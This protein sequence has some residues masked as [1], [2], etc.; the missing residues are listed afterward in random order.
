M[1][2]VWNVNIP[3]IR[4]GPEKDG[5]YVILDSL[6]GASCMFGYGVDV[7][8]IFDDEFVNKYNVPAY[9]FDHTVDEPTNLDPKITF[10]KE[11]ISDKNEYPLFT[12]ETHVK[13]H[14]PDGEQFMLKMD[15]E[16]AEWDVFK[17]ADLSRVTQLIA[18]IHDLDKA[19]IEVLELI[20]EK[21][22]LVHIHGNNHPKQPYVKIDRVRKM[23]VVLECTWVRK[24]L[25]D[26]ATL[27]DESYPTNL[28]FKND[29]ESQELE[30]NFWKKV[31][32]P[33]TFIAPDREQKEFLEKIKTPDDQIVDDIREAKYS[34]IFILR[35]GDH[36]PYDIIMALDNINQE[37]SFVFPIVKNGIISHDV[38]FINGPGPSLMVQM[39]IFNTKPFYKV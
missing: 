34:R 23:P 19:P 28:D 30:L 37:G 38:R 12:L 31:D 27:S 11:G 26:G 33:V 8:V 10:T 9:I 35:N 6:F 13:R 20:N 22:Y 24:D 17:T 36:V 1:F 29:T 15:V 5:G 39:P 25:V 21:F 18:E 2:Q 7:N 32:R 14:V 3:K 4:I 16:G